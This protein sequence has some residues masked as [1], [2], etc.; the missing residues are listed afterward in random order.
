[1]RPHLLTFCFLLL[2]TG[3]GLQAQDDGRVLDRIVAVVG[4][5]IITESELQLQILQATSANPG[6]TDPSLRMRILEAMMNDK[7]I[8]A[9]AELDSVVVPPEEVTRRLDEQVRRLTRAYG[10]EQRLEEV[11]GMTIAQMKREYRDDIRKRLMI[12]MIQQ[13]E[14]GMIEVTHREI[15]DFYRTYRDSL[16]PVPEQVQLRQI[17]RFPRVTDDFKQAARDKAQ[18]IL[19][20]LHDGA[21]FEEMARRHSDDPG[22]ARSGGNLGLA[23][24]GVFVRE[25]EEAAFALAEEKISDIVETQFGFHII[26]LLEKKGEAIRPQHILVKVEKTGESDQSTIDTL[27]ALRARILAGESFKELAMQYSEDE[28]TRKFGGS[29]GTIEVSELSDEIRV[30]QQRLSPGEISEPFK[31]TL[32]RDYAYAILQLQDRIPQHPV[33]LEDDYQRIANFARIFKQNRLYNE[34]MEKIKDNVYWDIKEI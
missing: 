16:P 23:R 18:S 29:L 20:S 11:V 26:K 34:W 9:Q 1:M 33:S 30:V 3:P 19:D 15:T 6:D 2:F 8:L 25:F 22:S 24:R 32:D 27:N 13:Q 12:E 17:V 5:E 4:N 10:S 28:E 31:L 7:L 14:L 21:S